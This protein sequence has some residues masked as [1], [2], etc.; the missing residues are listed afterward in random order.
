MSGR[1]A[2]LDLILRQARTIHTKGTRKLRST[3]GVTVVTLNDDVYELVTDALVNASKYP[4]SKYIST[5][6][7]SRMVY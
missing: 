1:D 2:T 6:W 7:T 3:D 5:I 4:E